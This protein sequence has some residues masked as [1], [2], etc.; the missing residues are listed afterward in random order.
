MFGQIN[1]PD[2]LAGQTLKAFLD[3]F[4]SGDRSKIQAYIQ[5]FEPTRDVDLLM[6]L[7]GRTGGFDLLSIDANESLSIK[8]RVKER[9]SST[10]AVG[11]LRLRDG[12]P[13]TI[14][15]FTLRAI[16]PDAEVEDVV[17]DDQGRRRV[18]NGA[19]ANLKEFYVFPDMAEKMSDA[20][21]NHLRSGDY[22][23]INDG[24]IF[25]ALLTEHL[26]AVSHDKH[27]EVIYNQFK[28]PAGKP[29]PSAADQEAQMTK[30]MQRINCG[31]EKIEILPGNIGYLKFNMFAIPT[32]C[33]ST[34]TAAMNFLSHVDAIIFDLRENHGGDPMMI[35]G[36]TR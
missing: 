26:R 19:D 17:L 9:A 18:I 10:L 14:D 21:G 23:A 32:I 8:F 2:S 12:L 22:D 1:I 15:T 30:E 6:D 20:L 31:F 3:A 35:A 16:P 13:T 24:A 5:T 36:E 27:L 4:N 34:A 11:V 7:R 25:A 28:W 33:G 29:E